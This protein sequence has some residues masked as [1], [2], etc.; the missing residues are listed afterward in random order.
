MMNTILGVFDDPAAA[1]QAIDNLRASALELKDISIISRNGETASSEHLSAGEGAT[2][3]A[4]WGGLVG[5]VALLIPGIGPF[6][7]GG[8]LFAALTGAATGA[9]VGGIAGA[10]IDS[11]VSEEEARSYETMVHSGKT[12]I[13]VKARDENAAAVRRILADA[14]ANSLR[15]NQTDIT[16]SD[17]PVN[18]AAY[19]T[20]GQLEQRELAAGAASVRDSS[21]LPTTT[22]AADRTPLVGTAGAYA[23]PT[24]NSAGAEPSIY[25]TPT[26]THTGNMVEAARETTNI[27][28]GT[29]DPYGANQESQSDEGRAIVTEGWER[30]GYAGD[31]Q[32]EAPK[33]PESS[34]DDPAETAKRPS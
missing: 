18:V 30:V 19:D 12:L 33:P 8:A 22:A 6:I 7:A 5:L 4:V 17:Q 26:H 23:V 32:G 28:A 20:P 27:A 15:D 13:A 3:G 21:G 1:R 24:P 11:G 10:L 25:D 14:G 34:E 16:G 29:E 31:R 9:V 2:V